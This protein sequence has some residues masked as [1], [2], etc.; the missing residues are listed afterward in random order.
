MEKY[1]SS[2][3][4]AKAVEKTYGK[5]RLFANYGKPREKPLKNH[6]SL[7]AGYHYFSGFF[8]SFTSRFTTAR[9]QAHF[10]TRFTTGFSTLSSSGIFYHSFYHRRGRHP[11]S[12]PVPN[13]SRQEKREVITSLDAKDAVS[14]T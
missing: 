6:S 12:A 3:E 8:N 9:N 13:S 14:E 5:V 10:T 2:T 4:W 1:P 7:L 11:H